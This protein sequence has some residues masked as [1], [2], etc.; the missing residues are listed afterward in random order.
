MIFHKPRGKRQMSNQDARRVVT[1]EVRMSFVH[2]VTPRAPLQGTGTPKYSVTLLIPK[3]DVATRQQLD[4]AINAT[5]QGG[6]AEKWGNVR[7][8]LISLPLHDGDGVKPSDGMPFGEEC[9]GHWVMTASD[10]R[11]PDVVDANLSPII[12]PNDLYSGMYGRVSIRF[13]P[14][15][16]SGKKGIGCG[17][18]NVQKTREGE[19]LSGGRSS[20]ADDFSSPAGQAPQQGY[21]QP[22]QQG[23]QQQSPAYTQQPGYPPQAPP[24]YAPP[25]QQGYQQQPPAYPQQ[26]PQ[27]YQ[28]QPP[29]PQAPPQQG[30]QQ[31]PPAYPQQGYAQQPAPPQQGY[32]Q[33]QAPQQ[34]YPMPYNPIT[35]LPDG[36]VMGI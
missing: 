5:I 28:P 34:G 23:Y 20:A 7:P 29:A 36:G 17:L 32:Q 19:A 33:P 8:P 21:Q 15:S 27:G 35:G 31:Q 10:E 16:N 30:Y 14:Y 2:L 24:A 11:R 13:F 18:G 12:N 22:P 6:V 25:G 9:R 4:A 26:P 3:W 1:G